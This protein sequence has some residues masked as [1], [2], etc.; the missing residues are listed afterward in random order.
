MVDTIIDGYR[1]DAEALIAKY[2][3]VASEELFAAV[4]EFLPKTPGRV[5]DI[6]AGTGRDA[7]WFSGQGHR[8]LAVEPV[9]SFV[10]AGQKIHAQFSIQWL[11]DRLP[12]VARVISLGK[13]FDLVVINGVWQHLTDQE[14]AVAIPNIARITQPGSRVVL[15]LRD[16]PAAALRPAYPV[17]V[18]K[19]VASAAAAGLRCIHQSNAASV[20]QANRDAGVSWT[21]LVFIQS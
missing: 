6:G 11:E 16:G 4:R 10:D 12:E 3:A 2:E 5:I 18:K 14:R 1:C 19:T 20:Q 13:C 9:A 7:A 17:D 21:W 8:V 15:S